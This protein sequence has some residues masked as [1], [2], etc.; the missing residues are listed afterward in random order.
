VLADDGIY[1]RPW[2][3]Y[4]DPD[5]AAA[6]ARAEAAADPTPPEHPLDAVARTRSGLVVRRNGERFAPGPYLNVASLPLLD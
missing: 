4:R 2:A 1:V 5:F 6:V 3:G